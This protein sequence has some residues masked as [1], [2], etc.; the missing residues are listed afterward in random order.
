M[1]AFNAGRMAHGSR[2][3]MNVSTKDKNKGRAVSEANVK[4][5]AMPGKYKGRSCDNPS[6]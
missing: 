3:Q 5:G 4:V 6:G 1:M 2:G